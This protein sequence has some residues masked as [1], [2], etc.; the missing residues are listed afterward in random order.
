VDESCYESAAD[1]AACSEGK[2]SIDYYNVLSPI[3]GYNKAPKYKDIVVELHA[4]A[5]NGA[6]AKKRFTFPLQALQ[7]KTFTDS[8]FSA[9][10]EFSDDGPAVEVS[11]TLSGVSKE[12]FE[13]ESTQQKFK[14]SVAFV[15]NVEPQQVMIT[16]VRDSMIGRM[17]RRKRRKLAE[18]GGVVV[19]FAILPYKN[20]NADVENIKAAISNNP[21]KLVKAM[22]QAGVPGV[23][24]AVISK[25]LEKPSSEI[26][27]PGPPG[28]PTT[29]APVGATTTTTK[30]P[31]GATTTKAPVGATTTTTKASVGATTTTTKASVGATTKAPPAAATTKAPPAAT[32]TTKA[33]TTPKAP[34]TAKTTETSGAFVR[35]FMVGVA[36]IAAAAMSS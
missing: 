33:P 13:S 18:G 29:K 28:P 3:G 24:K 20:Q 5:M 23:S 10:P 35:S 19:D 8:S 15:A 31:V 32:T 9:D 4:Y 2:I 36:A 25:V 26:L 21:E 11:I 1:P 27:A 16:G 30:A 6:E 12:S 14:E 7:S 22:T 34:V 17:I